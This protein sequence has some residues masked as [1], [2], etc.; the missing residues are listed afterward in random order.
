MTD[1]QNSPAV[2]RDELLDRLAP[3]FLSLLEQYAKDP[4]LLEGLEGAC[5]A[6]VARE[7]EA[8]ETYTRTL[9]REHREM[10]DFLIKEN[11]T[12]FEDDETQ[13]NERTALIL[14]ITPKRPAA[15]V[16]TSEV[17]LGETEQEHRERMERKR[18]EIA[19]WENEID[20]LISKP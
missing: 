11:T 3:E 2:S 13:Q 15:I 7:L 5:V 19:Y 8:Q 18:R 1:P 20:R 6:I 4:G 14:S 12:D 17:E 16:L 10:R 9:K